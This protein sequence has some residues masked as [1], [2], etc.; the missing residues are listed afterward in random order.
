ML[1]DE[2]F[3]FEEIEKQYLPP[4][5]V[6]KYG[7]KKKDGADFNKEMKRKIP[8]NTYL[9]LHKMYFLA[10]DSAILPEDE[11]GDRGKK[12]LAEFKKQEEFYRI[13][14]ELWN[15]WEKFKIKD[16][17]HPLSSHVKNGVL[18]HLINNVLMEGLQGNFDVEDMVVDWL[19][20]RLLHKLRNARGPEGDEAKKRIVTIA[21]VLNHDK[22]KEIGESQ[23]KLSFVSKRYDKSAQ[24]FNAVVRSRASLHH[25][26]LHKYYNEMIFLD[27]C[28]QTNTQNSITGPLPQSH[29]SFFPDSSD[30]KLGETR[31][32]KHFAEHGWFEGTIMEYLEPEGFYLIVYDDDD[33]ETLEL[34]EL[35]PMIVLKAPVVKA[36]EDV[37]GSETENYASESSS[38][39]S[40]ESSSCS[41]EEGEE[42]AE[43]KVE[44]RKHSKYVLNWSVPR[45]KHLNDPK[46]EER[47]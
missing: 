3:F 26:S 4:P 25:K 18:E 37:V 22:L 15:S 21:K 30:I 8:T 7:R 43:E 24:F 39:K 14:M 36:T 17:K 23:L 45:E 5:R 34:E 41:D 28:F 12:F 6:F 20:D 29:M 19:L 32:K 38:S 13:V 16:R 31:V 40:S 35:L 2:A 33:S 42:S 44:I 1:Y 9:Q 11:P 10:L 27:Q 47:S 46:T